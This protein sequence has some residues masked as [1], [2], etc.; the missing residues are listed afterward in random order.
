M[1]PVVEVGLEFKGELFVDIPLIGYL[2]ADAKA[3]LI[4]VTPAETQKLRKLTLQD[5]NIVLSVGSTLLS[6]HFRAPHTYTPT[7]PSVNIMPTYVP[8]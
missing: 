5:L 2:N 4:R 1:L 6:F 8:G 3:R 7:A